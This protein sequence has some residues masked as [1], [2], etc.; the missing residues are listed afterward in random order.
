MGNLGKSGTDVVI[1]FLRLCMLFIQ[2]R[3]LCLSHITNNGMARFLFPLQQHEYVVRPLSP[4]TADEEKEFEFL[5]RP[6][7]EIPDVNHTPICPN[8]LESNITACQEHIAPCADEHTASCAEKH[9]APCAEK[10]TAPC[11][12]TDARSKGP[13]IDYKKLR[14]QSMYQCLQT[15]PTEKY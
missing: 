1:H 13:D 5:I 10:H 8:L 11:A 2:S 15:N 3:S 7:E 12:E 4:L 14:I 6:W 9:T